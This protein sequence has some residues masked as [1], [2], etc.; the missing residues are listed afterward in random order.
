MAAYTLVS[1]DPLILL[2]EGFVAADECRTL[3][4]MSQAVFARRDCTCELSAGD[5]T[6]AQ[7]RLVDTL[8]DR[9]GQIIGCAPH[10]EEMPLLPLR[11]VRA[12]AS[13]R[14]DP[15]RAL[16]KSLH[17]D[18]NGGVPRRFA[19]A[20]L[21]LTSPTNGGQT[22]FPLASTAGHDAPPIDCQ[23][24]SKALAAS[25]QLLK[26]GCAHTG[27]SR[28]SAA[29]VIEALVS[30]APRVD[31][32]PVDAAYA[33]TSGGVGIRPIAGNL[34]VFWTR[35]PTGI[36]ERSWH[37]GEL[38]P[39]DSSE[40]KW[41]L[42]KFKEVPVAVFEDVKARAAFLECS[43]R[44]YMAP[45]RADVASESPHPIGGGP[46]MPLPTRPKQLQPGCQTRASPPP[47]DPPGA[48]KRKRGGAQ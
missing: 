41:L 32:P 27:N 3:L 24:R 22:V 18:T 38:V 13:T 9:I 31:T 35:D 12:D 20:L 45:S 29:R 44:P 36:S 15:A 33:A 30:H 48:L 42:R 1:T 2:Y 37:G 23:K 14:S 40:D 4:E 19:S 34:L 46:A 6:S 10:A 25:R 43:R 7:Q 39:H 21:Y 28:K 16:R 11:E 26:A 8:E 47:R 5:W 17:V